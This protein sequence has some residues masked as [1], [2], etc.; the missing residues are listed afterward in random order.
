MNYNYSKLII[1]GLVFLFCQKSMA[2]KYKRFYFDGKLSA[3]VLVE[4]IVDKSEDLNSKENRFWSLQFSKMNSYFRI[5][6]LKINKTK[7]LE[8]FDIKP[9]INKL[10]EYRNEIYAPLDST[11]ILADTLNT[12]LIKKKYPYVD[13]YFVR[14]FYNYYSRCSNGE[15]SYS[16]RLERWIITED[17]VYLLKIQRIDICKSKLSPKTK[18]ILLRDFRKL[19]RSVRLD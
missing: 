10:I 18:R 2:Q 7:G 17:Y 6:V 1:A 12:G 3:C 16:S 14:R 9:S 13:L 5:R 8:G 15:Y 19:C 4:N 11:T